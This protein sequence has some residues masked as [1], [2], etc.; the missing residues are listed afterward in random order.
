M[1]LFSSI[2]KYDRKTKQNQTWLRRQKQIAM[3][4]IW[5]P[6]K[7]KRKTLILLLNNTTT[8]NKYYTKLRHEQINLIKPK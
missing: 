3:K 7:K 1:Q 6:K 8:K 4:Q 5:K 2:A